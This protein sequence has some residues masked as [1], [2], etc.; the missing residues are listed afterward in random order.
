MVTKKIKLE[1]KLKLDRYDV[2]T[3]N[4]MSICISEVEYVNDEGDTAI[5]YGVDFL[6]FIN[7]GST[8]EYPIIIP[9]AI[10][11]DDEMLLAYRALKIASELSNNVL[12]VISVTNS[13][14]EFLRE[15]TV[16]EVIE[17]VEGI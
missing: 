15:F 6:S 17:F 12:E 7:H 2:V 11:E 4:T 14:G 9:C 10:A 3:I 1:K 5:G 13:N 8:K 16:S